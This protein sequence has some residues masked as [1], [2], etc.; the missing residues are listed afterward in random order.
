MVQSAQLAL[1]P[2]SPGPERA[3]KGCCTRRML[4]ERHEA[5]T[6]TNSDL[7]AA[8]AVLPRVRS[9]CVL[10]LLAQAVT[11]RARQRVVVVSRTL[12]GSVEQLAQRVTSTTTWSQTRGL[13]RCLAMR[14]GG[15]VPRLSEQIVGLCIHAMEGVGAGKAHVL[16]PHH[17]RPRKAWWAS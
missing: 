9:E 6:G 12:E 15:S 7:S 8:T 11:R 13:W 4:H 1:V 17:R 10:R 5:W 16:S 3:A 14:A 2:A